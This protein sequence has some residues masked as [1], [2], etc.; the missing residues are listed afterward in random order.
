MMKLTTNNESTGLDG[1]CVFSSHTGIGCGGGHLPLHD[2]HVPQGPGF[3]V[4]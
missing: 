3:P 2:E 4:L 1:L